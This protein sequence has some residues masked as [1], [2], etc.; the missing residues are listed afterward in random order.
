MTPGGALYSGAM[1]IDR[2][3]IGQRAAQFLEEL[4]EKYGDQGSLDAVMFIVAVDNGERD[5]TIEY[6]IYDGEG[7][8]LASWKARG[9][10]AMVSDNVGLSER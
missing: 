3:I 7:R 5:D 1:A 10:L 6:R 9:L 8:G 2:S 4:D